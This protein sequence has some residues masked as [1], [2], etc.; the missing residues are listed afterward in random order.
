MLCDLVLEIGFILLRA[1][2]D[3][4]IFELERVT[5]PAIEIRA[6][7]RHW[8]LNSGVSRANSQNPRELISPA[9]RQGTVYAR[10]ADNRK[11]KCH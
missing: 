10:N 2:R 6:E 3:K 4:D 11:V 8:Y 5:V 1:S 9:G 7:L